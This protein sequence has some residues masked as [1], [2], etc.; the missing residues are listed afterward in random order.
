M[1][2]MS[3]S[4]MLATVRT[5]M[6]ATLKLSD[7]DAA[8]INSETTAAHLPGWTSMAHLELVLALEKQFGVMFEAEEIAD[9]ASVSA[10]VA[11]VGRERAG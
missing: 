8:T 10:I 9:L 3:R 2:T 6:Q 1:S 4:D 5:C 7:V 11:A